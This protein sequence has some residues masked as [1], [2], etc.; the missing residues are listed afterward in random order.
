MIKITMEIL[1]NK[2]GNMPYILL[3]YYLYIVIYFT[4]LYF[5]FTFRLI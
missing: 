3:I 5:S 4:Y 2:P 1:G